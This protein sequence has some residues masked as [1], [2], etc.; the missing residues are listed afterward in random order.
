[1]KIVRE[2]RSSRQERKRERVD[3]NQQNETEVELKQRRVRDNLRHSKRTNDAIGDELDDLYLIGRRSPEPN[4]T[5]FY[6]F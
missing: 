1:M 5:D 6:D 3:K 4:D 2:Q